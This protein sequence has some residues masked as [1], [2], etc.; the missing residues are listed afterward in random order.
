M[1]GSLN[2]VGVWL[3]GAI[4]GSAGDQFWFYALRGRLHWLDRFPKLRRYRDTVAARVRAAET[5]MLLA[6]R[7]LP[8]LRVAIPVACAYAGTSPV[9]FTLLNLASALL[10]AGA[11]MLL[12]AVGAQALTAAGLSAWWGPFVPAVFV[13][14][15]FRWL[16]RRTS[17]DAK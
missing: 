10:W 5:P 7:F 12:V 2:W 17:G 6:C 1:R 9:K 15:F 11:I 13:I 3:A 4:G 14:L 8:G 16:G